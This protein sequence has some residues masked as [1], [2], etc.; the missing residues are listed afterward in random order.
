[1]SSVNCSTTP[2][3]VFAFDAEGKFQITQE[4]LNLLGAPVVTVNLAGKVNSTDD[5]VANSSIKAAMLANAV[6]DSLIT[7]VGTVGAESTTT[8]DVSIQAKDCQGNNL[9]LNVGVNIWLAASASAL[10]PTTLPSGGAPTI[11]TSNGFILKAM[12]A[13]EPGL[14]LTD[15]TGLLKLQFTE[16]GALTR[17]LCMLVQSKLVMGSQALIWTA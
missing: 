5:D 10:A 6:A 13:T 11:L 17:Y 14:Y 8:I 9:A 4:R 15:D 7:V 3:Y 16:A 1:M 12:T 2:G